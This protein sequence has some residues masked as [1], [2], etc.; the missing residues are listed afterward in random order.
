MPTNVVD[1]GD[2]GAPYLARRLLR[3]GGVAVLPTETLYGFSVLASDEAARRRILALKRSPPGRAFLGLAAS[4]EAVELHVDTIRFGDPVRFLRRV[5]PA[6]LTAVLP[7]ERALPWGEPLESG[8]TAAFRVPA[9]PRLLLLLRELGQILLS[10]SV[11]RRGQ[12]PL[13]RIAEISAAFGREPDVWLFRDRR[14]ERAAAHTSAMPASTVADFS[15]WP[16]QVLRPGAFDLEAAL[17]EAG[18]A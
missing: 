13:L 11:N 5:W 12:K 10:T 2:P 6:P 7:V 3:D 4:A 9:H 14:L 15:T 18:V 1:F 8:G 17:L 16:P